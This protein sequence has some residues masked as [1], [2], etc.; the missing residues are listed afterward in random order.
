MTAWLGSGDL[1][2]VRGWDQVVGKDVGQFVSIDFD[3]DQMH[4]ESELFDVQ[5][6]IAIDVRQLP[7]FRQN[8]IRQF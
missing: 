1:V 6:A 4:C 2:L 3:V 7:D 5:K 8:R